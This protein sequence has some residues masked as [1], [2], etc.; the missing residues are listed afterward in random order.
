MSGYRVINNLSA[1]KTI[2]KQK[3]LTSFLAN[4][5]KNNICDIRLIPLDHVTF[6]NCLYSHYGDENGN[7]F[8]LNL[9]WNAKLLLLSGRLEN[10]RS[11][12]HQ[13]FSDLPMMLKE[14]EIW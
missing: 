3:N 14:V 9:T 11:K 2:K 13:T 8:S 7:V 5:S 4:I 12:S 6:M 10:L 1:L